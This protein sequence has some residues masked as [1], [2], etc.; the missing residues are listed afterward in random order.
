MKRYSFPLAG[1]RVWVAGHRG[2]VG[3]ALV[4]RLV[5][6]NCTIL[7]VSRSEL[8]LTRQADV[9]QWVK[10]N[11]PDLIFLAAAKVGGIHANAHFP[12]DFIF[13]NLAIQ[14]NVIQAAHLACVGKLVFFGSS[15]TYPKFAP[16]PVV[17]DKLLEGAPEPT[18][19]WYAVAKIAGIKMAEAYRR[20]YGCDFINLMPA[21]TYGPNDNFDPAASHVIPSLIRKFHDSKL[22]GAKSV[23]IWGSGT[24]L[25]EFMHVDDLADAAVFLAKEYSSPELINVGSGEEVSITNL[26][27]RVAK[28]VGFEGELCFDT[29]KPDG[30]PRKLLDTSKLRV[31]GWKPVIGLDVGLYSAYHFFLEN[32]YCNSKP[33]F[34]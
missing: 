29:A 20:Q 6:E 22:S 24:P 7:T 3:N 23:E 4:H 9:E 33:P 21:N 14:T 13:Q 16:Q 8:D 27:R 17:E 12:A 31:L 19:I 2:M 34:L 5:R 30:A 26:A 32:E 28:V 15:C 18:N 1:R 25:R 10:T 11:A